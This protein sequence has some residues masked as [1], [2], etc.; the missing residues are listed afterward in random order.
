MKSRWSITCRIRRSRRPGRSSSRLLNFGA[1]GISFR[2]RCYTIASVP[3]SETARRALMQN[4]DDIEALYA[5]GAD[6]LI[7]TGTEPRAD[8][9]EKEPYW[10]DFARLVDWARLHTRSGLSGPALP[11]MPP[12]TARWNQTSSRQSKDQRR[13]FLRSDGQQL[14]DPGGGKADFGSAFPIQW[15][16]KGRLIRCGYKVSSWSRSVDVDCFWRR[17]PSFFFLR[18]ATPNMTPTRWRENFVAT[19]CGFWMGKGMDFP[20]RRAIIFP[21]KP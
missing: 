5:R 6:A 8:A 16:A 3:R 7:V 10:Q 18:R 2:L 21:S 4:H 1:Q 20:R 12:S 15:A 14:G 17:E 9:L 11:R 13:L 19:H